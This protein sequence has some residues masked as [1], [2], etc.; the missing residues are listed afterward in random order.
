MRPPPQGPE[1]I[2]SAARSPWRNWQVNSA[3]ARPR[4]VAGA[5]VGTTTTE[6]D[7]TL[8][9]A[10]LFLVRLL[11]ADRL[12]LGGHGVDV[13]VVALLLAGREFRLLAGGPGGRQQGGA[14]VGGIDRLLLGR[15][16]HLEV[17]FDLRAQ[18]ERDR[19][20]RSQRR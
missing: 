3:S 20:H 5:A 18:A 6:P 1:P 19:V 13:G 8:P 12:Q 7:S 17:E 16:L 15:A 2:F 4:S 9:P 11:A 14:A 10:R